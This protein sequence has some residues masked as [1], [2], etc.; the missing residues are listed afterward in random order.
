MFTKFKKY[1][2]IIAYIIF[3][4]LELF[5]IRIIYALCNAIQVTK[6]GGFA[7]SIDENHT[8]WYYRSKDNM[9]LHD[10]ILLT[11]FLLFLI[12]SFI[13][14]RKPQWAVFLQIF[15]LAFVFIGTYII[16]NF[17]AYL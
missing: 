14:I 13:F 15:W 16:K 5:Y 9:I 11:G 17:I 2:N 6:D 10:K 1:I 7:K 3:A 4:L 8:L 12:L